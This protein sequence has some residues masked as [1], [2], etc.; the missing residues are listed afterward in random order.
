MK[1]QDKIEITLEHFIIIPSKFKSNRV[2]VTFAQLATDL[3]DILMNHTSNSKGQIFMK[4]TTV[5]IFER[6]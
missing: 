2:A 3:F 5:N 6:L 4:S 1:S